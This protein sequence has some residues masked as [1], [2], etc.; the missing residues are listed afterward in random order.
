[1]LLELLHKDMIESKYGSDQIKKQLL[2]TLYS[3]AAMVGKN[4]RN[5]LSTDDEVI[6]VIKKFS[7]NL[8]ET[9]T[10]LNTR[11]MD[12][13]KQLV[14]LLI[15]ESYLPHQL[16]EDELNHSITTIMSELNLSG[17]SSMGKIMSELKNRHGSNYDGKIASNLV[18]KQL[19]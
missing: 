5:D 16:T 8:T 15:L 3:E 13:S 11:S 1:M 10:L 6:S 7:A 18:R 14:E 19:N 17:M 2:I 4:K 12:T 9:V